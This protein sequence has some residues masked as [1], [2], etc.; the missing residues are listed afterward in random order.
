MKPL[1][2]A[3]APMLLLAACASQP[4]KTV[5]VPANLSTALNEKLT[6]IVPA[7]GVQ[8]YECKVAANGQASWE[9]V[10][11]TAD[12]FDQ[13][14]TK[15]GKH[16]AGPTWELPDGSKIVGS[17]K[18]RADA[19]AAGAI[20]WL[21]LGAKSTGGPGKF[22]NVS[23]IQRVNTVGGVA[24]KT[25]CDAGATGKRADVPYTADYYYFAAL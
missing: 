16:Y 21:L 14:G 6:M 9:F 4:M 19:P 15:I 7:A 5:P 13:K 20:P 11:P 1:I 10:A 23:S 2:L 25:G 3:T 24:P 12:L 22:A 17:V 18:Q 8:T